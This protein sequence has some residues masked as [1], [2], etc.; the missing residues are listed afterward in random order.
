MMNFFNTP[1][2]IKDIRAAIKNLNLRKAAGYDRV[3]AE[4]IVF[5][6]EG[7]ENV[8]LL[9]YN[10]V[11]DLEYIPV[12]FRTGV[13]IPL[14]KGKNLDALDPNNYRGIT[15]VSSFNKIFE[16]LIW[17]R[18]KAWWIDERVISD[19]Q[20]ACKTGLSCIHTAFLLQETLATSLEDNNQ[21]FVAFFGVAK[22]FDTVWIDG[23][24]KQVFDIGITGKTWSLLYCCYVDFRCRVG[25]GSRFSEPYELRC[26]IH[27]GGT[28][29]F[30]STPSL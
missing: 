16:I 29:R 6:G 1:F 17:Q 5:A 23:L 15:L 10:A 28:S 7:M 18:L 12:C 20:G 24:F 21:C 14:F 4:H 11:L 2:T 27:Q 25:I 3:T 30:W 19:L 22:A 9:L 8:L 26:G 13:Q